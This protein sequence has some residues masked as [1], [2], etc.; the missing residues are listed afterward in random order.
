MANLLR[1][2]SNQGYIIENFRYITLL[3]AELKILAEIL[4]KSLEHV[5][6]GRAI[7]DNLYI[8]R[9]SLT[10]FL[11]TNLKFFIGPLLSGV[12]SRGG[13]F[14]S[15]LSQLDN[16]LSYYYRFDRSGGRFQYHAFG[17]SKM[18]PLPVSICVGS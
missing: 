9:Y 13:R 3:N 10:R 5:V 1:N 16:Y 7:H 14:G 12:D 18:A 17:M 6:S 15:Y 8:L 4:A 11:V 2:A